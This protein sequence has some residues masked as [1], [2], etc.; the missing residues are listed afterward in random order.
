MTEEVVITRPLHVIAED[1]Y[2]HWPPVKARR[3]ADPYLEVMRGIAL[4]GEKVGA[5]DGKHIV[6]RFL[7]NAQGWTG[8]HARRIK[9]EL[10]AL[11]DEEHYIHRAELALSGKTVT[12][13][14]ATHERSYRGRRA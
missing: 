8:P 12:K 3:R 4:I 14:P 1:I 2:L 5:D 7:G 6:L 10:R 11:I 13:G 9:A